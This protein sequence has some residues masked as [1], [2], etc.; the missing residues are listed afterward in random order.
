M[1]KALWEA[2]VKRSRLKKI[3]LKKRAQESF[4]KYKKQKNTAVGYT[5]ES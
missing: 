4:K 3:Y 5:N 2:I 1:I